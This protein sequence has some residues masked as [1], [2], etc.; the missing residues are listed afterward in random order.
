[1]IQLSSTG[2]SAVAITAEADA[3]ADAD[4]AAAAAAKAAAAK[5]KEEGDEDDDDKKKEAAPVP[6]ADLSSVKWGTLVLG[7]DKTIILPQIKKDK[8]NG[9]EKLSQL[10]LVA[11]DSNAIICGGKSAPATLSMTASNKG[12]HFNKIEENGTAHF[13]GKLTLN[14][15]ATNNGGGLRFIMA[16]MQYLFSVAKQSSVKVISKLREQ[17]LC[18][19]S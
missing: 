5:E 2:K 13:K 1:M 6:A 18:F 14:P 10:I 9:T 11:K 15:V 7:D 16:K 17:K 12:A 3:D 19:P 4:A 8:A